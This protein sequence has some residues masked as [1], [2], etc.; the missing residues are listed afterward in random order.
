MLRRDLVSKSVSILTVWSLIFSSLAGF[1]VFT[2]PEKGEAASPSNDMIVGADYSI[3]YWNITD[4]LYHMRGNLII[5]SGGIVNV[6][7]GGLVFDQDTGPDGI[8]GTDDD[9]VY[10]LIVEDGGKLILNNSILTTNLNQINDYPSLGVIVRNGG[11]L[12]AINSVLKFPGHMVV[13]DSTLIMRNSTMKGHSSADIAKYCNQTQFPADFFDD[14]AVL[15]FVSSNIYLYD[16]SITGL[17]ERNSTSPAYDH[18][19]SFAADDGSK[20]TVIYNLTRN[21]LAA[22]DDNTAAGE[23]FSNLTID[24]RKLFAVDPH[25]KLAIEG[26]DIAGLVFEKGEG[27]R[28]TLYAKYKTDAGYTGTNALNWSFRNGGVSSSTIVPSDTAAPY[29][30]SINNEVTAAS[31]LPDMSSA[32][33]SKLNITFENNDPNGKKVYFNRIWVT[34]EMSLSTYRN[35][36]LAGSTQLT[37]VNSYLGVDFSSEASEHNQLVVLDCS[38]AYLYGVYVDTEQGIARLPDRSMA[39]VPADKVVTALPLSRGADDDT[40]EQFAN[41]TADDNQY[42]VVGDGEKLHIFR[43]NVSDLSGNISEIVMKVIYFTEPGYTTSNYIT[44]YLAGETPRNSSIR[45]VNSAD[46]TLGIYDLFSSGVDSFEKLERLNI[47]FNNSGGRI[48]YFERVWLE[49]TLRPNIYIYKWLNLTLLDSQSLPVANAIVNVTVSGSGIPAYYVSPDGVDTIPPSVVLEYL[50]KDATSFKQTGQFGEVKIPLLWEVINET[51]MPNAQQIV[52]GYSVNITYRNTTGSM[53]YGSCGVDFPT[54]PAIGEGDQVVSKTIV[55]SNLVVDKP[56]LAILSFTYMPVT[57]YVMDLVVFTVRVSNDGLTA[58]SNIKIDFS[59]FYNG[60]SRPIGNLTIAYLS[61]GSATDVT[62]LWNGTT[63]GVHIITVEVDKLNLVPESNE[64]NNHLSTQ[65]YVAPLLPDLSI[66]SADIRIGPEPISTGALSYINVTIHN[67]LGRSDAINAT[68]EFY[69]GNPLSGGSLLGSTIINVPAGGSNDTTFNW[70]PSQIGNYPVYVYIN[71]ERRIN[72]YSY[73]NNLA[74]KNV[75]VQLSPNIKD[76]VI[77]DNRIVEFLSG[78][79][80]QGG[81]IIVKDNG[82]LILDQC[83]LTILQ[84]RSDEFVIVVSD[85][86]SIILTSATLTSDFNMKVYLFDS[87]TLSISA[88]SVPPVITIVA[89]DESRLLISSSTLACDIITPTTSSATIVADNTTFYRSWS[90]FGGNAKAHLTSIS[91]P[92][93]SPIENAEAWHYRWLS[94]TV[95]DGVDQPLRGAFVN[96][97]YYLNGTLYTGALTGESGKTV[98]RAPC[99]KINSTS[100]WFIGNYKINATYWFNGVPYNT[101]GSIGASLKPYSPPAPLSRDDL[102]V[103]VKIP[104]ALP[105]LDPPF[106]VSNTSPARGQ[107]VTLIANITNI[108]VVPARNVEVRFYDNFYDNESRLKRTVI[109]NAIIPIINP[110]E[111]VSVG[112][113]WTATL[114]LGEHNLSVVVDPDGLIPEMNKSNNLNYTIVFVRGIAQLSVA[115]GGFLVSPDSPVTNSSATVSVRVLN[116]GDVEAEDVNVSFYQTRSGSGQALIGYSVV[117]RIL[118]GGTGIA[119]ISWIPNH[120][121]SWTITVIIDENGEIEEDKKTDNTASMSVTVKNYA[122]LTPTSIVFTPASPVSAGTHIRMDLSIMN[123]GESSISGAVVRFWLGAVGTGKIIA[124]ELT[125]TIGPGQT[126]TVSAEWDVEIDPGLSIQTRTIFVIVNPDEIL[127]EIRYDNNLASEQ[128]V[129]F[130]TRSDLSFLGAPEITLKGHI[131]NQTYVGE[132]VVIG[133]KIRNIGYT[134]AFG[135]RIAFYAIDEHSNLTYLGSITKDVSPGATV[136]ANLT[137]PVNLTVGTYSI[138]VQIDPDGLIDES[139][140]NNNDVNTSLE[141]IRPSP[142]IS[143]DLGN[144]YKY[145]T[146]DNIPVSGRV[147]NEITGNALAGVAVTVSLIDAGGVVVSGPYEVT[148]NSEGYFDAV[149]YIPLGVI[150]SC[151]VK[152]T[153]II[154]GDQ[155]SDYTAVSIEKGFTETGVDWWIYALIVAI[156]AAIIIAFS[157]YLYKYGLGKMVECGECGALIPESSRRCPKCGVEFEP[158]TVKCSEC[159]A[160]IP[161]NSAECPECGAKFVT[162]PI[163]EEEDEYIKKMREQYE[164]SIEIYREQARSVLG[165]KY[166]EEKFKQWWKKQPTYISFEKWLSQEEERRKLGAFACPV[167]GTLNARGSTVCHKCGTVFEAKKEVKEEAPATPEEKPRTLRRIVR[168][169]VEKK[170]VPKE[171]AEK[172]EEAK[173]EE[174][175]GEQTQSPEE[176]EEPKESQ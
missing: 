114:P 124:E 155:T 40:G 92:S 57:I 17:L 4:T 86:A 25:E 11:V 34:V 109:K 32:D 95:L 66:T 99:D 111:T 21:V 122:D 170:A 162:E 131:V 176:K 78:S 48:V 43:F 121:G 151:N 9:H 69:A 62:I 33:L 146:G 55:L 173:P 91:I 145:K 104:G 143:I 70:I 24:D 82:T 129:V 134:S 101:P 79:Y 8:A 168:R 30:P 133:A 142:I 65:V 132:T 58:A 20:V 76:L 169:P 72:E 113:T 68:V 6:V 60:S 96:I 130:D 46:E 23:E 136:V 47:I 2:I 127:P 138:F 49:I 63:S 126:G 159:G 98:V 115:A 157:A 119:T 89:D 172:P 85:N 175:A 120:P 12:E 107:A 64:N 3:R 53:F 167:C 61:A 90:S 117:S 158:G 163:P 97:A 94:V 87:G 160:W 19:Y 174:S 41:L 36:T 152:A 54:Y 141:I 39:Y 112:A 147:T 31:I 161:A 154:S 108:G 26:I 135:A 74:F 164:K 27:V 45:P 5:R 105:D 110:F 18:S 123:A 13:D 52:G 67:M 125:G 165:K 153:T 100:I 137:W 73:A 56:D 29:D 148:T 88:S 44:W 15:A 103:I 81:N 51:T 16:S 116:T 140:R 37:A 166:S 1:F 75:S 71:P 171:G 139:N 128:L 38:R 93:I 106:W 83:T 50:G 144:V 156:V 149:V 35:I 42:Y 80:Y 77:D 150:G 84:Q 14:F 59:D 7:N 10:T 118:P 102:S 28:V 22:G